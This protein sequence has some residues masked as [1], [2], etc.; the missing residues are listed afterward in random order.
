MRVA[1]AV[2]TL[3]S[4]ERKPDR[5]LVSQID[6]P[7]NIDQLSR[8]AAAF[9]L[10]ADAQ[11]PAFGM[12]V[13]IDVDLEARGLALDASFR[14]FEFGDGSLFA[15]FGRYD[16]VALHVALDGERGGFLRRNAELIRT[17]S[18]SRDPDGGV[19]AICLWQMR[20][21]L[22]VCVSCCRTGLIEMFNREN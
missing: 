20:L 13:V 12:L 1:V 9:N 16:R 7:L 3:K 6:A 21:L 17:V 8:I 10:V 2:L 14:V 19:N 15:G 4:V 11:R 22:R 18:Q 5:F